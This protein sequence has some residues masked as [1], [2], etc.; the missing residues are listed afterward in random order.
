[1]AFFKTFDQ[2]DSREVDFYQDRVDAESYRFR[3]N[4]NF[5]NPP[6]NETFDDALVLNYDDQFDR[7]TFFYGDGITVNVS[8]AVTGGRIGSVVSYFTDDGERFYN[9]ALLD[10][11]F[12]ASALYNAQISRSTSDDQALLAS[13][14]RN[15]DEIE[16]S[17]FDDYFEA[18]AGDD[19]MIGARGTD[20]LLGNTGDDTLL[21]GFGAD[22]LIGGDGND[23]MS[24]GAGKDVFV[25]R[26]NGDS[27]TIT[28]FAD[29]ADK[30]EI[31]DAESLTV[32][33]TQTGDDVRIRF[34]TTEIFVLNADR[35]DFSRSDFIFS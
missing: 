18:R 21:G 15:D 5:D 33:V 12:S 8:G 30:I 22:R 35:D 26:N 28:A 14:Y 32:N 1:M 10:A 11:D 2:Y 31:Q 23:E 25:F 4:Q 19:E 17:R 16:L 3:N 24:G 29:G 34:G 6:L 9:T 13:I 7:A 27:E 20:T